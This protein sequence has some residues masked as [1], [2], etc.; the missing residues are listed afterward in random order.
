LPR[1]FD[2][3]TWTKPLRGGRCAWVDCQVISRV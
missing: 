1:I 3:A 2:N